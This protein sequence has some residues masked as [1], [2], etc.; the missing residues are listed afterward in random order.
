QPHTNLY[1]P[2]GGFY[3]N[4]GIL[5]QI[6]DKLTWQN[7]KPLESEPWPAE[8]GNGNAD[9][10]EYPFHPRHGVTCSEGTPLDADAVAKNFDPYGLGDKAQRLPVSEVINNYQRSEVIDPLT[11]K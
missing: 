3:P 4:G 1:P 11:V 10:T 7:P 8:R 2:A 5:N 9:Q 6:T